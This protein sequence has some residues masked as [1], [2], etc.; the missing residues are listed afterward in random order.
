MRR[1][2]AAGLRSHAPT[3]DLD[4][5]A[6]LERRRGNLTVMIE[7]RAEPSTAGACFAGVEVESPPSHRST[8]W[9]EDLPGSPRLLVSATGVRDKPRNPERLQ[10]TGQV[11]AR[12]RHVER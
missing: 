5:F 12:E 8:P 6:L 9:S 11:A 10:R 7:R 1:A 3:C 2:C 4:V